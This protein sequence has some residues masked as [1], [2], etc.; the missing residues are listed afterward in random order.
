MKNLDVLSCTVR[1]KAGCQT[2][3][4]ADL[5]HSLFITPG[6][7]QLETG[8]ISGWAPPP[9]CLPSVYLMSSHVTRSPRPPP[10]I[11]HTGSNELL[12]VGMA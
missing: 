9:V 2:V 8:I 10:T 5:Y 11:F 6:T 4:E 3:C 12:V 1:P 7:D